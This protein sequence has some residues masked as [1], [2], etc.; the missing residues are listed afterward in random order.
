MNI[1]FV[2]PTDPHE[3]GY[4]G[5]QRTHAL[6]KAL[7][8]IPGAKVRVVVPV[9][10]REAV[11]EAGTDGVFHMCFDKR[12]TPGWFLGRLLCRLVP[13]CGWS[14][15]CD[16]KHLHERFADS[17]V[18]VARQ[19]A[20]VGRFK[21]D[22]MGK[23]LYLDA[24]D[25]H[26][27]EFDLQTNVVGNN[28]WR[29]IQRFILSRFQFAHYSRARRIWV[30]SFEHVLLF[31][32]YPM[33]WLPNIPCPPLPDVAQVRGDVNRLMFVGLM[34]SAPNFMA[35][36]DFL[37]TYW[38]RLKGDFPKLMI[39]IAGSGLPKRYAEEWSQYAE[40]NVFGYVADIRKLY[41]RSLALITPMIMGAG[42]CIKV[43]E[44]LRMGRP[45]I[46]TAQGLRGIPKER[47]TRESGILQYGSYVELHAA[48]SWLRESDE[49]A[50]IAMAV[51]SMEFVEST[52]S[53]G[54][55]NMV[56][57]RDIDSH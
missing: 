47:R 41:E 2:A 33:S 55:V 14:F 24:D 36:D 32:E 43:L 11:S 48:I 17:D 34:A 16:W 30:P 18:I 21:L 35:L 1:L 9:A 6:W 28:I 27:L 4:G 42:T 54:K 7:C 49:A 57:A 50:R 3:K 15:G 56:L 10:R 25:I 12:Y 40:V 37:K 51:R 22:R 39:D 23:P 29:R 38:L 20:P 52:Y 45:V 13:Y 46:S 26:T 31:P 19:I 53:Q 5:Q 44:A 8:A